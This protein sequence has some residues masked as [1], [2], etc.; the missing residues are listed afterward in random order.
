RAHGPGKLA[1]AQ[2]QA[3]QAV[4]AAKALLATHDF[5]RVGIG[6]E[7]IGH[8][9]HPGKKNAEEHPSVPRRRAQPLCRWAWACQAEHTIRAGQGTC[10]CSSLCSSPASPC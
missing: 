8:G 6:L 7:E 10:P 4:E 5:D 1:V 2:V 3:V 9:V